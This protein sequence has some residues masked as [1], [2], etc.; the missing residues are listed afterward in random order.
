MTYSGPSGVFGPEYVN[1]ISSATASLAVAPLPAVR[2]EA[3]GELHMH[4]EGDVGKDDHVG[5]H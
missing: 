2:A 3:L 1:R 5:E 4:L